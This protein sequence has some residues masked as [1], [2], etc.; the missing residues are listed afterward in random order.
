MKILLTGTTG[1]LGQALR[2]QVPVGG[3]AGAAGANDRRE[4]NGG[5]KANHHGQ[6]PHPGAA[7]AAGAG[8][9]TSAIKLAR[10]ASH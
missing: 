8:A 3:G 5:H 7:A 9:D 6:R 4:A 10:S 1:Q 2:Q